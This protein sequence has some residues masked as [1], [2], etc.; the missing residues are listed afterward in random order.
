[1]PPVWPRLRP[2]IIG[3][4]APQAATIGASISE[5]VSPTPP[6]EC[7]SSTG[8]PSAVPPVRGQS[9]TEPESRIDSVS[10]TRSA[11]SR[12][13]KKIAIANAAT[14]PSL[15]DPSVRPWMKNEISSAESVSPS[16]FL[17]MISC[18]RSMAG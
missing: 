4:R 14:W 7:L 13:R 3:T 6:V 15:I 1:M 11:V 8:P 17:R 18:G 12:S 16:R 5:T 9:S 2:E 10:A